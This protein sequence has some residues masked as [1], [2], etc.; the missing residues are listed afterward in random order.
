MADRVI[1]LS[2]LHLST[3]G[4]GGFDEDVALSEFL[5]RLLADGIETELVLAGDVFDFLLDPNY[6]GYDRG[7]AIPRLAR[8]LAAHSQVVVALR[9]F[10][11]QAGNSITLLS[12]NHDPEL[13]LPEVHAH[14]A[15]CLGVANLGEE[16]ELVP[17]GPH[18][19]VFGRAV[20]PVEAPIWIV[21]GDR[22]DPDNYIDRAT[23]RETGELKLPLGSR[24]VIEVL[25]GLRV[26][27]YEWVYWLKPEVPAVIPLLL[28][29]DPQRTWACVGQHSGLSARLLVN[30]LKTI[31][32]ATGLFGPGSQTDEHVK[33]AWIHALAETSK[34]ERDADSLFAELQ[35]TLEHGHSPARTD[36][37]A[38][39]GGVKKWLIRAWLEGVRERDRFQATDGPDVLPPR[40]RATIPPSVSALVVGH[41]HGAR[42]LSDPTYVNTGT[43]LPV[44]GL[45]EGDVMEV[46]DAIERGEL[47]REA[48][49]TYAEISLCSP[50]RVTLRR[51]DVSGIPS[52]P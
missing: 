39:H 52:E 18:P 49:R 46:I 36:S 8:I 48:P 42:S 16:V 12:G 31:A 43:W 33:P 9:A 41:T 25:R 26:D 14:V 13:L 10:A 37:L 20:G 23:L 40:I 47:R 6:G 11:A 44:A 5:A 50:P 38:G 51:C 29:L 1:V 7:Q 21:H 27:G 15:A 45:P 17:K 32:R 2:D 3:A 30:Q 34:T 19:A 24:L 28:Y 35:R 4:A 22:W